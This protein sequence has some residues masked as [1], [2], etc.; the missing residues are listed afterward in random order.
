MGHARQPVVRFEYYVHLLRLLGRVDEFY[1]RQ[2]SVKPFLYL[3]TIP[4]VNSL[5]QVEF[6]ATQFTDLFYKCSLP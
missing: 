6:A 1:V 3:Q 5:C 4:P 2:K